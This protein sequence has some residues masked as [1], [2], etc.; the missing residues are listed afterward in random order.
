MSRFGDRLIVAFGLFGFGFVVGMLSTEY[1]VQA[2]R[3]Q[4]YEQCAAPE[5]VW[6]HVQTAVVRCERPH[7]RH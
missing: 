2:T 5:E 3:T 6:V 1:G 4:Y 7:R